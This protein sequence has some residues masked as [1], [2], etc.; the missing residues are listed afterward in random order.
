M[1]P[2]V[3][4]AAAGKSVD[5]LLKPMREK[6]DARSAATS[7]TPTAASTVDVDTASAS[8][9]NK[10]SPAA[11]ALG[12]TAARSAALATHEERHATSLV[13]S[14]CNMQMRKLEMKMAQFAEMEKLLQ[15]ERRDLERKRREMFLERLAWRR[16]VNNVRD[17]VVRCAKMGVGSEESVKG[18]VEALGM[19]GL[20]G[21]G[22]ELVEGDVVAGAGA[23]GGIGEDGQ[24]VQ[25]P[26]SLG[27]PEVQPVSQEDAGFR[28]HEI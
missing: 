27:V 12:L 18:I 23:A 7:D 14:A 16:R 22:L 10:P 17:E 13:S 9:P 8:R 5:D 6:R 2:S 26:I 4:A 21:Q 15:A 11:I 28:S 3:A 1:D 20:G 25:D 19:L 24:M